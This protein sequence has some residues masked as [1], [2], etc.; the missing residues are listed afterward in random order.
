MLEGDT[1]VS[2]HN[3]GLRHA[4]DAP[5]DGGAALAVAPDA[6][7]R[8]A[9]LGQKAPRRGRIV[10]VVDAIETDTG[11]AAQFDEKRHLVPARHAPRR[12]DIDDDRL[13]LA[14][15]TGGHAGPVDPLDRRQ[16]EI[17][18][19]APDQRRGHPRRVAA[20]DRQK[21]NPGQ[22]NK[23][24]DGNNRRQPETRIHLRSSFPAARAPRRTR[25]PAA[26]S[27]FSTRRACAR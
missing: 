19:I 20:I 25:P 12:P 16:I 15:I 21:K 11:N 3:I 17:G 9:E 22:H 23:N 13:T 26:L 8:I 24:R 4:I 2:I 5:F 6:V 18:H 10:L 14:E 7:E 27:S 1:A